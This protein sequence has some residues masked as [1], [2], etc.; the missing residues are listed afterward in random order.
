MIFSE[1]E[2][3]AVSFLDWDDES[4]GQLVKATAA[5]IMQLNEEDGREAIYFHACACLL[6]RMAINCNATETEIQL[7]GLTLDGGKTEVGDYLLIIEKMSTEERAIEI[8]CPDCHVAP[9]KPHLQGCSVERCPECGMQRLS[10]GCDYEA[11]VF[12]P[13]AGEWPGS[14]E[15]R[16]YGLYARLV[17]GSGWVPCSADHPEAKEDLNRLFGEYVWDKDKQRFVWMGNKN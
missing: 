10:C 7:K 16:E 12:V 9:G 15:C 1:V 14:A 8:K 5:D 3:A 6:T 17:P 11:D 4:I 2:K 13:W